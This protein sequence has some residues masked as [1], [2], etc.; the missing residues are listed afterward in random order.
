MLF[1]NVQWGQIAAD[2]HLGT[3][4]LEGMCKTKEHRPSNNSQIVDRKKRCNKD[5]LVAFNVQVLSS[6]LG[7]YN[8]ASVLRES[9]AEQNPQI[10]GT[11][12]LPSRSL[13]LK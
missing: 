12:I 3:K 8:T 2:Q 5:G 6:T 11:T 13:L 4:A 7:I 10:Y 9:Q 1:D